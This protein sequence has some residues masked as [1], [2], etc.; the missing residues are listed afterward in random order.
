MSQT[1]QIS[2]SLYIIQILF[3]LVSESTAAF[4][5]AERLA[6]QS[7]TESHIAT[8]MEDAKEKQEAHNMSRNNRSE[9]SCYISL[10][11][12]KRRHYV[13]RRAA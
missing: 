9:L 13:G 12:K 1:Y 2:E 11:V 4:V 7:L 10:L 3:L 5:M 6:K 8:A